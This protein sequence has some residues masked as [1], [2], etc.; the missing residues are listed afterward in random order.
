MM[1]EGSYFPACQLGCSSFSAS[2]LATF[3]T[4]SYPE[5]HGIIA[6]R[7]FERGVVNAAPE[8]LQAT[9]LAEQIRAADSRNRTISIAVNRSLGLLVSG[10][11]AI[12][13]STVYT[14]DAQGTYEVFSGGDADAWWRTLPKRGMPDADHSFDWRAMYAP[15]TAPPLR[16]LRFDAAHPAESVAEWEASPAGISYKF[17]FL[18]E[19]ITREKLGRGPGLDYISV[20]LDSFGS[21]ARAEGGD[22][23][24]LRELLLNFDVE[25]EA[26]LTSLGAAEPG[27]VA[28]VL[29]GAHGAPDA[30]VERARFS[31]NG[32]TLA[33][34]IENSLTDRFG[35][36]PRRR[37]E[38]YLYP[39]LYL[40]TKPDSLGSAREMRIA[41]G[42]AALASGLVQA[43]YTADGDC[44]QTGEFAQRMRNSFHATRSGDVM[45]SYFPGH[46]EETGDN[47]GVSFGSLY[48]YDTEVPLLMWGQAFRAETFEE[49]V[50]AVD[51][52]PTL[53]RMLDA[54]VPSSSVGKTL[55]QV[56]VTPRVVTD[57]GPR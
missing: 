8:R 38:T 1:E 46:V 28:V 43:Y 25:L 33:Q 37:V 50:D 9:T 4:G 23:V 48:N 12:K 16:Q 45:F 32:S 29:N 11:N 57:K 27:E 34:K 21:L 2:A 53:A 31:V 47:R 7:W 5:S 49:T 3:H 15:A 6:E 56:F 14:T 42:R 36:S 39:F 26:L 35:P 24:L 18:R 40:R 54:G 22:S 20:I 19:L 10:V 52:A 44:S 30:P 17:D 55:A 51:L 41:A 13:Q